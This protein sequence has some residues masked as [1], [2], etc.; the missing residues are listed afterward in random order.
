MN[1]KLRLA[2]AVCSITIVG[3]S[4]N[5]FASNNH[6]SEIVHNP[7]TSFS[8]KEYSAAG[9]GAKYCRKYT[10]D[11]IINGYPVHGKCIPIKNNS[12]KRLWVQFGDQTAG[13]PAP[14]GE[15][16][17]DI[18]YDNTAGNDNI[19]IFSYKDFMKDSSKAKVLFTG[20]A[21]NKQGL[22]CSF[23]KYKNKIKCKPWI[24]NR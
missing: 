13:T 4:Y 9:E 7:L 2:L 15:V 18:N 8:L 22:K 11:Y 5:S 14:N 12:G 1:N 17:A 6:I 19:K 23:A 24:K 10:V 20:T 3:F 16:V 21:V